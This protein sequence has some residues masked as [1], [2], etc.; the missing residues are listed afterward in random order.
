MLRK[1]IPWNRILVPVIELNVVHIC[2]TDVA[3]AILP[4]GTS[5]FFIVTKISFTQTI[6][7]YTC[8]LCKHRLLNLVELGAMDKKEVN[9]ALKEAKL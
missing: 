3:P 5:H 8:I 2:S 4:Q 1:L 6:K 7:R 9:Q